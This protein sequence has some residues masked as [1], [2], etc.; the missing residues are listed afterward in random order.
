MSLNKSKLNYLVPTF[1]TNIKI[2]KLYNRVKSM[3][4]IILYI[5]IYDLF[6]G[7]FKVFHVPIY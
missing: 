5:T 7:Y 4:F 2:N 1:T 6:H 3:I